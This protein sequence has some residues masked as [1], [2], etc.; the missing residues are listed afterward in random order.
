MHAAFNTS[1]NGEKCFHLSVL[2]YS[3]I[4]RGHHGHYSS[5]SVIG[6]LTCILCLYILCLM[7][8]TVTEWFCTVICNFIILKVFIVKFYVQKRDFNKHMYS[9]FL[10]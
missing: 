6:S 7:L 9:V 1:F 8:I 10:K 2:I 4:Y 3:N 5:L